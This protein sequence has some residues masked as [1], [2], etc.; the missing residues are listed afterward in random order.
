ML[1]CQAP[2][3]LRDLLVRLPVRR[4]G[5]RSEKAVGQLLEP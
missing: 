4:E 1:D 3:Y 5:L 2:V